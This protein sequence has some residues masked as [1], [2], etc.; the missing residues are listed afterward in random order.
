MILNCLPAE[1][2]TI[3]VYS[4][5]QAAMD[6][7]GLQLNLILPKPGYVFWTIC[8]AMSTVRISVNNMVFQSGAFKTKVRHE[9]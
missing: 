9:Y 8:T 6:T 4:I 3:M 7:G 5:A 2:V 1:P